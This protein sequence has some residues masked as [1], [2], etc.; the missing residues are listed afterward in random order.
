MQQILAP[1][2]FELLHSVRM[3]RAE[4]REARGLDTPQGSGCSHMPIW[5]YY[6]G[7]CSE[8]KRPAPLHERGVGQLDLRQ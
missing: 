4:A 3:R 6:I 7:R 8:K 5:A 2:A 1:F